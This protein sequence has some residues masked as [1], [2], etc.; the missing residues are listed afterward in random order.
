MRQPTSIE[1]FE[2]KNSGR[3]VE[4]R[5]Y[6]GLTWGELTNKTT[7]INGKAYWD[8]PMHYYRGREEDNGKRIIHEYA[9]EPFDD[10]P[11]GRRS[12]KG[13]FSFIKTGG[14]NHK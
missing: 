9:R 11:A 8:I 10:E 6:D 14:R 13:G 12:R 7:I 3:T 1:T 2:V 5:F 4:I